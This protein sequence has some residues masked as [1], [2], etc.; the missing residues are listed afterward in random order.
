MIQVVAMTTGSRQKGTIHTVLPGSHPLTGVVV[1]IIVRHLHLLL[2]PD[3]H[4]LL[5]VG[6]PQ[7][8]KQDEQR[9]TPV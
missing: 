9:H 4:E 1:R 3:A 5:T 2:P 8:L 6:V 7:L